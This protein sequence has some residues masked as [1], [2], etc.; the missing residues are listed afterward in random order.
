MTQSSDPAWYVLASLAGAPTMP[1]NSA[2]SR[3]EGA[4]AERGGGGGGHWTESVMNTDSSQ[5][6]TVV[7]VGQAETAQ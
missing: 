2:G 6:V 7:A 4:Q 5:L 1:D 3:Q